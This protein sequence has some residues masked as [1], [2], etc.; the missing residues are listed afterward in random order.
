MRSP[1]IPLGI[2]AF[3]SAPV[4]ALAQPVHIETPAAQERFATLG[5]PIWASRDFQGTEGVEITAPVYASWSNGN[6]VRLPSGSQ[7]VTIRDKHRK[8]CA[9]RTTKRFYYFKFSGWNACLIDENEDGAFDK[10]T[11]KKMGSDQRLNPQVPYV[12][13]PVPLQGKGAWAEHR[14][15]T[16]LGVANGAL[17][18]A[19][20]E[21]THSAAVPDYTDELTIPMPGSY[22][23]TYTIKGRKLTL[24]GVDANA[25]RYRLD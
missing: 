1:L 24:L 15:L 16:Y 9:H 7:L 17:R 8:S 20:R 11:A 3:A 12:I 6:I 21:F 5:D 14:T 19:Y 22:P 25:M 18:M 10:V 13:K 4:A 23:A 2:A